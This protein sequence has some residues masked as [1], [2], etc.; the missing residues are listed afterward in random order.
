MESKRTIRGREISDKDIVLIRETISKYFSKGRKYI[1]RQLC[2]EWKWYQANGQT[3]DMACR[4]I[5]LTLEKE[6]LIKLPPRFL[7]AN[8][9]KKRT[10]TIKLEEVCLAG[11]LKD[12]LPPTLQLLTKAKEYKLFNSIVQS[13]HYQGYQIIVGKFLKYIA[14]ID[15]LAVAC[16]GW[17]SGVWSCAPRDQWIGWDKQTKDKNLNRIVNNTRF[18]ILPWIKIKYLASHLL[19]LSV[20]IVPQDWLRRYGERIYLLETFVE[21]E[22]FKG[23][24]YKAANWI[25]LGST[26]G[27]AKRGSSH[28]Y[29][30]NIKDIW[31]YPLCKDFRERL[32]DN[33]E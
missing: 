18:L 1:S 7:S 11:T 13:Y 20:K 15:N 25:Y 6:N 16:L 4:Y 23:T 2:H 14:Y 32:T 29:H 26:K 17:G 28:H 21:R 10:E 24:C 30:G 5:L 31:V 3:K 8:N 9:E 33:Y 27:S 19:S 22:R 12:Y